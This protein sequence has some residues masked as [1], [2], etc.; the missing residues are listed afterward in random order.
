[1][2]AAWYAGTILILAWRAEAVIR[3]KWAREEQYWE[4]SAEPT[5]SALDPDD[6]AIPGDLVRMAMNE[7]ETWARESLLKAI[8]DLYST[9]RNWDTVRQR[10]ITSATTSDDLH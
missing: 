10:I 7:S 3:H 6:E 9:T 5:V 2:D 4:K 8:R 1:M